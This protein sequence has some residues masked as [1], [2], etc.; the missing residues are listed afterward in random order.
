M[1]HLN[2]TISELHAL[3]V[4]G[5]TTPLNVVNEVIAALEQDENNILEATMYEE[6]RA[7]ARTLTN[8]EPDN[9]LWGIPFLL[10]DN[11][12]TKDVETN[13][14]SKILD[15]YLPLFDAEVVRRLKAQKAI[16][17]AKTTLDELGMGGKGITGHRGVTYNPY[18]TPKTHIVGGSSSGS[19]SGV[20]SGYVPFSVGS[21]TGD[22]VRKPASY[23]GLVGFKPTWGEVSRFGLFAFTPSLDHIGYFA[24]SVYDAALVFEGTRGYDQ[25]D[26]TSLDG[27]R[28]SVMP[29]LSNDLNGKKIAIIKPIIDLILDKPLK[30]AFNDLVSNL[31]KAGAIITY[32]PFDEALLKAIFP[33]Y[34]ILSCSETS[35]TNANLDGINFGATVAGNS[36]E[37]IVA[38]TRKA[39]FTKNI[40][41]RLIFGNYSLKKEHRHAYFDRA[42]KVRRL[43][44]DAFNKV[45]A[46]HDVI[47]LP[48]A[49]SSAP[50]VGAT[51]DP[52]LEIPN[53]YLAFGNFG[54]NPSVTLP[55]LVEDGLPIGV[56]ITGKPGADA[57]VLNIAFKV[58][59][60]T[61]LYNLKVEDVK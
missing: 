22:S 20:A 15:G 7:F 25:K 34:F 33:T 50:K 5:L 51:D 35:A 40:K 12:S 1:S 54:G 59:S 10:K 6:A 47:L 28:A 26:A 31:Q 27:V 23:A 4:G 30:N 29:T 48:A 56:N 19:A 13:G 3:Y 42:Q 53:N 43:I 44:V 45:Y 61:G 14:S 39:G 58:E 52:R 11:L 41:T 24:R 21:D 55:L 17:I 32:V 38:N 60:L 16:P 18:G 46:E 9:L 2:L 57:E 36:Y 37:E 8:V 49:P